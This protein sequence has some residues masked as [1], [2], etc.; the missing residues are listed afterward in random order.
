M[1]RPALHRGWRFSVMAGSLALLGAFA[2]VAACSGGGDDVKHIQQTAT[3]V[4]KNQPS[5]TATPDAAAAYRQQAMAAAKKLNDSAATLDQD[6]LKAQSNQSDPNVP[7][8]L[9]ADADTLAAAAQAVQALPPAPAAYKDYADKLNQAAQKMID[10]SNLLKQAIKNLDANAGQQS[11]DALDQGR[12]LL[13]QAS[14]ALPP[15]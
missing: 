13:E 6:L 12:T 10:S 3:A 8:M 4:A 9:T 11:A 15:A 5:P 7:Q 14:A 1:H 2:V